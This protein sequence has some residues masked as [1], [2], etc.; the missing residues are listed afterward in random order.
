LAEITDWPGET[1]NGQ[2]NF[3]IMMPNT[4]IDDIKIL[5][6]ILP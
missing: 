5:D 4:A 2:D 1:G 3:D 6:R